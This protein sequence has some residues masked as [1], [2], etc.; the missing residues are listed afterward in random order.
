MGTTP[1]RES[2]RVC[3]LCRL[4]RSALRCIESLPIAGLFAWLTGCGASAPAPAAG[5]HGHAPLVHRFEHAEHWAAELEGPER[6][7]WQQPD[8]VIDALELASGML[9]ADV[10]AGTGYF[11]AR[12]SRAVG[13]PGKVLA[14]DIEPDMVRH[15]QERA[16]REQLNNVEARL[17]PG[18][19]PQLTAAS[20]DRILIVDT[21]HHIS[22]RE[23]YSAKLREALKPGGR[24]FIVDFKLDAEHGPPPQHR[25]APDTVQRELS[26]G[27]L[28]TALLPIS[29]PEQYIVTGL[30]K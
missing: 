25:L 26:A 4:A 23:A 6:D 21:W 3:A 15:L 28:E 30:R 24:V 22:Q 12:L 14:L 10:G 2:T 20:V 9:V 19:D 11:E 8:R 7:A 16:A 5:G 17:V 13:E 29:L 1:H 18:D 27:G